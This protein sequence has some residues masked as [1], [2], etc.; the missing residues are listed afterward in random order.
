MRR[1]RARDVVCS[2]VSRDQRLSSVQEL[3]GGGEVSTFS[4]QEG[5]VC[6]GCRILYAPTVWLG[7]LCGLLGVSQR[8]N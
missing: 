2:G 7:L 6:N 8:I 3:I 4:H 1:G 5:G